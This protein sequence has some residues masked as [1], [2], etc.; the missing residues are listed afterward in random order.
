MTTERINAGEWG[1][2]ERGERLADFLAPRT[3]LGQADGFA[4]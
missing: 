1:L 4:E 2:A 3:G